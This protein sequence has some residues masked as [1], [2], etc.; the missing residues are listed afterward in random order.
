MDQPSQR[1]FPETRGTFGEYAFDNRVQCW[2]VLGQLDI[3]RFI[4]EEGTSTA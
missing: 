1:L 3:A 2:L 4:S